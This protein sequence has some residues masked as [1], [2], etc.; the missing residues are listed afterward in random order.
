MESRRHSIE[1][2]LVM[3]EGVLDTLHEQQVAKSQKVGQLTY[4]GLTRE[5]VLNPDNFPQLIRDSRF[6]YE[7]G[8]SAGILSSKMAIRA[9]IKEHFNQQD[10]GGNG[11]TSQDDV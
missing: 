11:S 8:L 1:D 5:D 9:Y 7:D 10:L 2:L 3:L 4:P 6:M